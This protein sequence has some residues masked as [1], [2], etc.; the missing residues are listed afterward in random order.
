MTLDAARLEF[1]DSILHELEDQRTIATAVCHLQTPEELQCYL[2]HYNWNDGFDIPLLVADHPHCDTGVAMTLFWSVD[3]QRFFTD[4]GG[5]KAFRS[6]CKMLT[7]RILHGY[8]QIDQTSFS[9][10]VNQIE[11]LKMQKSGVPTLFL[12][13]V[14]GTLP[15]PD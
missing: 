5:T 8:Y 1:I 2:L 7:S 6:F 12:E 4:E 11:S 3:G 13:P 9:P 15:A 10:P 14:K